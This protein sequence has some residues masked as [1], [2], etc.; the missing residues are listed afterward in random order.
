MHARVEGPVLHGDNGG[1]FKATAVLA[2]LHWLGI[3]PSYSLPLVPRDSAFVEVPQ[4]GL[5]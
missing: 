3:A 1:I 2:V 4:R 5:A